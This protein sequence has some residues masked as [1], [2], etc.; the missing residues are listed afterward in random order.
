[1]IATTV[2]VHVKPENVEDF[3][4]EGAIFVTVSRVDGDADVRR[5]D[6]EYEDTCI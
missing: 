4:P 3:I 2:I 6:I 1:M 5:I